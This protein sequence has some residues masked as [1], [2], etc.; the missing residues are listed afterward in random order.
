MTLNAG[1]IIRLNQHNY[2]L[3]SKMYKR[4]LLAIS[5]AY[6]FT[7]M[8]FSTQSYAESS[9]D[10]EVISVTGIKG[11]LIRAIDTK[12]EA[13]GVV[14]SISAEDIGKFPDQNVAESLQRI[15]GV[16]IDRSGGEGQ[17]IT[18]RG[19]GPE[20]NTVLVNGRTMATENQERDFSF[21]TLASELISGTEV[22][23]TYSAS[24]TEGGIGATVNVTTARPFDINGT[25]VVVSAKAL[26][27]ELSGE[28]TPQISGLVTRTLR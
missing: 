12:R 27:E 2:F 7:G 15:P 26:H 13:R 24:M 6:A 25:K 18:V 14:D 10:V 17:R 20:F 1:L 28:T 3:E 4:K 9:E 19:F 23:K 22:Y 16:S 11:S 8:L 5:V 21:D